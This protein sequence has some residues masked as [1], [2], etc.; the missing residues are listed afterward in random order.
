[1]LKCIPKE[2]HYLTL[3]SFYFSLS[4][5]FYRVLYIVSLCESSVTL[6]G[7]LFLGKLQY[8]FDNVFEKFHQGSEDIPS[9]SYLFTLYLPARALEI[10]SG[11]RSHTNTFKSPT[12]Q[13]SV[14]TSEMS[15]PSSACF[16]FSF[17]IFYWFII[18][19]HNSGICCYIFLHALTL[20]EFLVQRNTRCFLLNE[21]GSADEKMG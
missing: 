15:K 17:S 20:L 10:N 12:C 4:S 9:L 1:M 5:V 13:P 8:F 7:S 2:N 18:V 11:S 6:Q 3:F 21:P 14:T 16:L 19:V